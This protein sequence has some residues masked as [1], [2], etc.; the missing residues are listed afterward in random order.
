MVL[1]A[2][3]TDA[4]NTLTVPTESYSEFLEQKNAGDAKGYLQYQLESIKVSNFMPCMLLVSA[5]HK[6]FFFWDHKNLPSN[7]SIFLCSKPTPISSTASET[8]TFAMKSE[9]GNGL[10]DSEIAK[11]LW[12]V[13]QLPRDIHEVLEQLQNLYSLCTL[14]FGEQATVTKAIKT[15]YQHIMN[16]KEHYSSHQAHDDTFLINVLQRLDTAVQLHIRSWHHAEDSC[17]VNDDCLDFIQDFK[18]IMTNKFNINIFDCLKISKPERSDE[19]GQ[20]KWNK[21]ESD[22]TELF[23]QNWNQRKD[24]KMKPDEQYGPPF[25]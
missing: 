16:N 24:W 11:T 2:S 20:R 21:E 5:L 23:V 3:S 14:V 7:F 15:M 1:K 18:E 4:E 25:S 9:N 13:K 17:D 6:G 19:N 8:I 22:G 12:Q 10:T